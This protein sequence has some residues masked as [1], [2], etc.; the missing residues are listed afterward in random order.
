MEIRPL[1][2]LS[3]FAAITYL[4]A[5]LARLSLAFY[6]WARRVGLSRLLVEQRISLSPFRQNLPWNGILLAVPERCLGGS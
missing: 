4:M 3:Y 5:W 2:L 1:Y 6:H